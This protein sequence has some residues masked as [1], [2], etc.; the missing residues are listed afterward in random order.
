MSERSIEELE[1]RLQELEISTEY[2]DLLNQLSFELLK[3]DRHN[4]RVLTLLEN[5]RKL[6]TTQFPEYRTG[7][8]NALITTGE[9]YR[10]QHNYGEVM[11][12]HLEAEAICLPLD[13]QTD[14]TVLTDLIRLRSAQEALAYMMANWTQHISINVELVQ[15][16]QK[17]GQPIMEA[18]AN[19]SLSVAH[20]KLNNLDD[21]LRYEEKAVAIAET[22]PDKTKY[23]FYLLGLSVPYSRL[24]QF[25]KAVHYA[26]L[27]YEFF[28]GKNSDYE[29]R[30]L[31]TL[32]ERYSEM[33]DYEQ[34]LEYLQQKLD[35]I[36]AI[37][38]DFFIPE[39]YCGIGMVYQK[40][41]KTDLALHWLESGVALAESTNR[42]PILIDNYTYLMQAYKD[43]KDFE[44]ALTTFEKLATL[45]AETDNQIA[46]NQRN[47][48]LVIHETEQA[49]LEAQLQQERANRLRIEA[50]NLAQQNAL[51]QK[52]NALK[53]ELVATASHDMRSPL[54]AIGM[55]LALL[56][57]VTLD[58]SKA[59]QYIERLQKNV[60]HITNLIRDLL[61]FSHIQELMQPDRRLCDLT[62]LVHVAQMRH[63][64]L[65]KAKDIDLRVNMP[66]GPIHLLLDANQFDRV[67]DNLISNAI[68]YTGH[69][70]QVSITLAEVAGQ[71]VLSVRDNGRGI[72]ADD[73]PR[74]FESRFRAS[75]SGG[76]QGHGH[77]LS[78]VKSI[79][80]S[81]QGTILCE[82]V[83][84][85]GS[86][87]IV[88]LPLQPDGPA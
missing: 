42:M 52:I 34:A 72:P 17:V 3:Q 35:L 76:E 88:L 14:Q 66:P 70:G 25:D 39:T 62:K 71:A 16:A 73:I 51:F 86:T 58:N 38:F 46:I 63:E 85:A 56:Q 87:F 29:A 40:M 24:K 7:L 68:K 67:L 28:R 9:F 26:T 74:V 36:K 22:L 84:G 41:G 48:L 6:C 80:D 8:I 47:T 30:T 19:H 50:D 31:G 57:R 15:L 11:R 43:N 33:G 10:F 65:G 82:S 12:L 81:H 83:L 5:S 23:S 59:Q 79:V 27:A 61:D 13:G 45:R 64:T 69:G 20:L 77:G 32:G 75:N 55:E 21:A 37:N 44:K 78:I 1:A 53:D 60:T 4:Q 18:T 49:Q 54:T 2:I